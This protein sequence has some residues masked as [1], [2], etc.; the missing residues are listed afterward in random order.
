[1]YT[2]CAT[3]L[4]RAYGDHP[5]GKIVTSRP[6]TSG[7]RRRDQKINIMY[8]IY[9]RHQCLMRYQ[10]PKGPRAWSVVALTDRSYKSTKQYTKIEKYNNWMPYI[11]NGRTRNWIRHSIKSSPPEQLKMYDEWLGT[12]IIKSNLINRLEFI[13]YVLNEN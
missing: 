2:T 13:L 11:Q 7:S 6:R 5:A 8:Y 1:V 3:R 10:R 4:Q 9:R 12:F